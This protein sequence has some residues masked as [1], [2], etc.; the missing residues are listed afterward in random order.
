M[1][2]SPSDFAK[3][4]KNHSNF[5]GGL[6]SGHQNVAEPK[7]TLSDRS[8]ARSSQNGEE[9]ENRGY[10]RPKHNP[11]LALK[12]SVSGGSCFTKL[13]QIKANGGAA[14]QNKENQEANKASS[15]GED[16]ESGDSSDQ[17]SEPSQKQSLERRIR[18][19]LSHMK[20]KLNTLVKDNK[21]TVQNNLVTLA[22]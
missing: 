7:G 11:G 8:G 5:K 1:K 2:Q 10:S 6:P 20:N 21:S 18:R 15:R 12:S 16:H 17:G 22:R 19:F 4:S 13:N 3:L 9:P 14:F